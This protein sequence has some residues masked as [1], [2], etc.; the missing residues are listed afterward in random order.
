ML[1]AVLFVMLVTA[2]S[3]DVIQYQVENVHPNFTVDDCMETAYFMNQNT[4]HDVGY[5]VYFCVPQGK[6]ID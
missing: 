6:D 5:K 2:D 1:N 4:E 3:G